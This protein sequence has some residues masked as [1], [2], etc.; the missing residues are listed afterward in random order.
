MDWRRGLC[1]AFVTALAVGTGIGVGVSALN[2]P[3]LVFGSDAGVVLTFVRPD[4]TADFEHVLERFR[5][6]LEASED[7]IRR[8]QAENWRVFK[9]SDPGPNG[10]VLYV[11][12]MEPVLKGSNYNIADI[13]ADEL[14]E[15]EADTILTL[16]QDSLSQLQSTLSLDRVLDLANLPPT[17]T[18]DA[19]P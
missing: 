11:G 1:V 12:F 8:Q 3:P 4:K 14:P 18:D 2:D 5:M 13:M 17:K 6:V 16:L 7:P 10:S 19:G 9:S 15:E